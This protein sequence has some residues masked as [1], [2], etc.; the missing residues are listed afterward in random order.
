MPSFKKVEVW[1]AQ[2]GAVYKVRRAEKKGH[3]SR[4]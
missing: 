2:L 4:F 1:S 3:N